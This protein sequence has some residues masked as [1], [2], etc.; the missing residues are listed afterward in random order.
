[1]RDLPLRSPEAPSHESPQGPETAEIL[2]SSDLDSLTRDRLLPQ[3]RPGTSPSPAVASASSGDA[4]V[5]HASTTVVQTIRNLRPSSVGRKRSG[6]SKGSSVTRKTSAILGN[7]DSLKYTVGQKDVMPNGMQRCISLDAPRA[8]SSCGDATPV[9]MPF[10]KGQPNAVHASTDTNFYVNSLQL[11]PRG[12]IGVSPRIGSGKGTELQRA[13]LA[14]MQRA[15]DAAE[16]L[17]KQAHGP[18]NAWRSGSQSS[19]ATPSP[20]PSQEGH[21]PSSPS[22]TRRRPSSAVSRTRST[23]QDS[24]ART[25]PGGELQDSLADFKATPAPGELQETDR[26][27]QKFS[28]I[29]REDCR[30]QIESMAK[31]AITAEGGRPPLPIRRYPAELT[32][33]NEVGLALTLM[34][35]E[36]E[37]IAEAIADGTSSSQPSSKPSAS[38]PIFEAIKYTS[39]MQSA[40]CRGDVSDEEVLHEDMF[41]Q[42]RSGHPLKKFALKAP[43]R[44]RV[45]Q[46]W[47]SEPSEA[48]TRSIK[49]EQESDRPES[50]TRNKFVCL[51]GPIQSIG[52]FITCRRS[53]HKRKI[54]LLNSVF[55]GRPPVLLFTYTS[56]CGADPRDLS[57]AI[58]LEALGDDANIVPKMY[59][60]HTTNVHP[61]NSVLNTVRLGGLYQA[62]I[63]SQKWALLWGSHPKPELLRTFHQFQKTNHFPGSWQLGRKDLMWRNIYKFKRQ[64]PDE[65]NITPGSYVL[66]EDYKAWEDAREKEP[67]ALWIFK[68]CN[69]SC[70]RGIRLFASSIQASTEKWLKQKAGVVQR[71]IDKPL[72]INGYKFDLRV[73]VV[74]TSMDPLRVYLNSEGLVRFAT[75]KYSMS[76][77]TLRH[78]TM[79]LTNYSVNKH[80]KDYVKNTDGMSGS[81][82]SPC[83]SPTMGQNP[84]EEQVNDLMEVLREREGESDEDEEDDGCASQKDDQDADDD[85]AVSKWSFKQLQEHFEKVGLDYKL[86]MSRIKDLIVKSLISVEPVIVSTWHRGANFQGRLDS[87]STAS[88]KAWPNQT[89]FELY[90]FDVMV[91]NHLKPW[92]L[93]VNVSPS[94]SSSSPLDK[95]IKTQLIADTLT[96]VGLRAFDHKIM[97]QDMSRE[98]Q[99]RLLGLQPKAPSPLKGRNT[100]DLSIQSQESRLIKNALS[101]FGEAE[102]AL[103]LDV[104]DEYMRRGALERIFP[105]EES[106]DRNT[107]YF[108]TQ[109][110]SNLVLSTWIKAGGERLFEPGV[111]SLPSWLPRQISFHNV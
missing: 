93:E 110:Y 72:L 2:R 21:E 83:P 50:P 58:D 7:K 11:R 38:S 5:S 24:L 75:E 86:M 29:F 39:S 30:N 52:R 33:E 60:A 88:N 51:P 18:Q 97:D 48:G 32:P 20:T 31:S 108:Q 90:G 36:D 57:R 94:L 67:K 99:S 28:G 82:P 34:S 68:P 63:N 37:N 61:Y 23:R 74:V 44:T 103:I 47:S 9:L 101:G 46:G 104:H 56:A 62:G 65:F 35:D 26:S 15:A 71:Y 59:F 13:S 76:T 91:D 45:S 70:G 14:A 92:L 25:A 85:S 6:S 77:K 64:W 96:V 8:R 84:E 95:R 87:D 66:P 69:S 102:W 73:Y 22:R 79:H 19:R 111:R 81:R 3:Q 100:L 42:A 107:Q 80:S 10:I 4:Q 98:R 106:L 105:T 55:E 1:M 78:T 27:N 43:L 40:L 17:A 89:C 12:G 109:R 41:T 49:K 54:V 53:K 16:M